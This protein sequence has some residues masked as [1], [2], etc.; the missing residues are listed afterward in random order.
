M[1]VVVL[2]TSQAERNQ[3]DSGA[4]NNISRMLGKTHLAMTCF[5]WVDLRGRKIIK[6]AFGIVKV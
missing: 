6:L 4:K 5:E 1:M 3:S 2:E